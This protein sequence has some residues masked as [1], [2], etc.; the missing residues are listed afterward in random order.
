MAPNFYKF[1]PCGLVHCRLSRYYLAGRLL[2]LMVKKICVV[3]HRTGSVAAHGGSRTLGD[4]FV[5]ETE[6]P[7]SLCAL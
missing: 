3:L 1:R 7:L 5:V 6:K 4:D 2:N